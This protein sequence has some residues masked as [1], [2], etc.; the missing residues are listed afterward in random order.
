MANYFSDEFI[1]EVTAH[2]DIVDVI[3][4][5][6]QLKRQGS[7]LVGLCPFHREKTPSFH[8][9]PDKQFYH[10]FGCGLGGTVIKFVMEA[11]N[12]DFVEAVKFLAERAGIAIPETGGDRNNE[13]Y[14]KKQRIYQMNRLAAKY[15]YHALHGK[16]AKEAQEYVKKRR[17]TAET[18][19]TFGIGY[20]PDQ[21][22]GLIK[23]LE[24]HGFHRGEMVE[25]GLAKM[26]EKG[27]IYD[28]FRNRLMFP[29]FDVRGNVIAFG[30]RIMSGES[31]GMKYINSPETPVFNKSRNLF[32]L[33]FAKKSG[34]DFL[35]LAEGYMDVI[36]L[37]Q[38]GILNA[39]AG[40]GTAFTAEQ[41][42]IISKYT[43]NVKI[44]YDSDE[45]GIAATKRAIEKFE[46]LDVKVEIIEIPHGKDPDEYIKSNSADSFGDLAATAKGTTQYQLAAIKKKYNLQDPQQ[47]IS[48]ANEAIM[49]FASLSN[50]VERDLQIR[51]LAEELGV[52]AE[53]IHA[54]V[55]KKLRTE[56]RRKERE[57]LREV[58]K[59]SRMAEIKAKQ[60]GI[61][62]KLVDLERKML[63]LM[64]A[65]RSIYQKFAD[66]LPAAEFSVDI[67]KRIAQCIYDAWSQ[68]VA[69]DAAKILMEFS[70]E[71][72]GEVTAVLGASTITGESRQAAED[73][74]FS[75]QELLLEAK[76][77]SAAEN[78]Q[79]DELNRLLKQKKQLK[80]KVGQSDE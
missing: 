79:I 7:G 63:G 18:I 66:Q 24:Q 58:V 5:Y 19:R 56:S 80:R 23:H 64:F 75:L 20:A 55:R 31:K 32:S 61:D 22:D 77:K 52:S 8:V 67:H 14:E 47:K 59:E 4:D 2:N 29:V 34:K 62:Y 16:E 74:H 3:G 65:D 41:A 40:L 57:T 48:F 35:I 42:K 15:F 26:S 39:V 13:L 53:S 50:E 21:W 76:I 10:C 45:A 12:F 60:Q 6:V 72:S 9:S 37:Y 25:A 70:Q 33:N 1:Q 11:E 78:G 38:S 46:G 27:R 68:G 28:F 73:V 36:S 17:L 30:G 44:C 49:L 51:L 71:D 43:K 69:P 54:E